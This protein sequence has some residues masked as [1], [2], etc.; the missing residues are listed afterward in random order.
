MATHRRSEADEL[1]CVGVVIGARGLGGEVRVKSFTAEAADVAA[2]GALYDDSG[3]RPL[4]LRVVAQRGEAVVAR[5]DGVDDRTAAESLKGRKLYVPRSALPEP[6]EDEYYHADLIG[7]RAELAGGGMLGTVRAVYDFGAG[8]VVEI[9]GQD[10]DVVMVPFTRRAVPAVDIA[11]GRIVVDPPNV[12]EAA[13]AE[14]TAPAAVTEK[15]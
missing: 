5:V 11:G 7:L 4:W 9:G 14:G 12:L 8:A 10:N 6:A 1:L 3:G 13:P 15:P 2:Y